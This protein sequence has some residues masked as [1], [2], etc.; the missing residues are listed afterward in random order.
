MTCPWPWTSIPWICLETRSRKKAAPKSGLYAIH[1]RRVFHRCCS[2]MP[3]VIPIIPA[4][5]VISTAVIVPS[6]I[7]ISAPIHHIPRTMRPTATDPDAVM[8]D[9]IPISGYPNIIRSRARW[10]GHNRCAI[11]RSHHHRR[12]PGKSHDR[13]RQREAEGKAETHSGLG[14]R[15]R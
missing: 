12:R 7:V 2:P 3:A 14:G 15:H 1:S 8:A 5:I 4:P 10:R 6:S 13:Q 11:L 9:D